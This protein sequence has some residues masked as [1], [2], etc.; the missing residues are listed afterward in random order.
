MGVGIL[1]MVCGAAGAGWGAM[2]LFN[3]HGAADKAAARRDA[4]RAVSAARTLDLGLAQP[5]RLG[6]SFFRAIG[7]VVLP[8]G[9]ILGLIGLALTLTG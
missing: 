7:G 5:S 2:F 8:C 3:L 4:V 9:L 6:A 1:L